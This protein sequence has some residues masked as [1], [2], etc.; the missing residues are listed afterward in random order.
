M[1][2]KDFLEVTHGYLLSEEEMRRRYVI[3][4][5]LFCCGIDKEEYRSRFGSES[6]EDYPLLTEWIRSGMADG[7]TV[8]YWE[9][10]GSSGPGQQIL[11]RFI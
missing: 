3:K 2:K 5:I 10:E 9:K 8:L 11:R 1:E 7:Y 6:E 4:N